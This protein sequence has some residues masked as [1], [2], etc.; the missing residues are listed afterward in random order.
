MPLVYLNVGNDSSIVFGW[1][2]NI[3][4]V[5]G[6]IGWVVIE[7]TYLRFYAGLKVQRYD[8]KGKDGYCSRVCPAMEIGANFWAIDTELPYRSPGQPYTAWIT[9]VC[10][11]LIL[12][13]SGMSFCCSCVPRITANDVSTIQALMYLWKGN[14]PW[15]AF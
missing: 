4:T 2:V 7:V 14:L 11:V 3:T 1:L 5:S 13:T 10:L 8:R 6:L 12:L 15:P 9:L